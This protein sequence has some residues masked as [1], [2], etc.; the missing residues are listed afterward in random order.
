MCARDGTVWRLTAGARA[1]IAP[2][3]T[4]RVGAVGA[5]RTASASIAPGVSSSRTWRLGAAPRSATGRH[6]V[7]ATGERRG[8]TSPNFLFVDRRP[9]VG[10]EQLGARGSDG[11]DHAAG[12]RRLPFCIRD[13]RSEIVADDLWF[14]NG[15]AV[16]AEG[17]FVYVA[18]SSAFRVTRFPIRPTAR[19]ARE[20]YGPTSGR[21]PT[22]RFDEA[23]NLWATLPMPNG[24]GYITPGAPGSR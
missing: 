10:V 6:E 20:Q 11:G 24:A 1:R 2:T 12:R 21:R 4:T 15:V 8:T 22:D 9:A 23:G 3:T 16:D 7:L 17:R 13:G 18:E 19:S 5:S 14:A